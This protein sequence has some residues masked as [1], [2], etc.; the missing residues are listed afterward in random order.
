MRIHRIDIHIRILSY[1]CTSTW[2]WSSVSS[3]ALL[4]CPFGSRPNQ[5]QPPLP[6]PDPFNWSPSRQTLIWTCSMV[7]KIGTLSAFVFLSFGTSPRGYS[8]VEEITHLISCACLILVPEQILGHLPVRFFAHS[9]NDC[10]PGCQESRNI[11]S[12]AKMDNQLESQRSAIHSARPLQTKWNLNT[13]KLMKRLFRIC[14]VSR[15]LAAGP[16][17]PR[18]PIC[19][20]LGDGLSGRHQV[21]GPN[22]GRILN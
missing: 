11:F 10:V 18:H 16:C 14:C 13:T 2:I 22:D 1:F 4:P 17:V 8:L 15:S 7:W 20:T 12:F 19:L 9:G 21:Y 5:S 6:L 3:L